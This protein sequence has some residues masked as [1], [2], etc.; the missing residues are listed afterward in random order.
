MR[1][2]L[3]AGVAVVIGIMGAA[4][5]GVDVAVVGVG[6]ASGLAG[7][8]AGFCELAALVLGVAGWACKRRAAVAGATGP[9]AATAG[10][11][12]PEVIQGGTGE[13]GG[14]AKYAVDARDVRGLQ[15]GENNIQRNDFRY[16]PPGCDEGGA[17]DGR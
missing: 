1:R 4:G 17:A 3:L 14:D 16:P 11:K 7:V 2:R 15:V 8:M 10:G 9:G 5:L 6:R 13:I 12:A